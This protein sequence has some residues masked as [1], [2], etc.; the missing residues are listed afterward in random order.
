MELDQ[1]LLQMLAEADMPAALSDAEPS[2][3]YTFGG[4]YPA[5]EKSAMP[6]ELYTFE[7]PAPDCILQAVLR[8]YVE[9]DFNHF[10]F[11]F[12]S[13]PHPGLHHYD[14]D[15]GSFLALLRKDRDG[16]VTHMVVVDQR[17]F[18]DD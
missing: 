1:T 4:L 9:A 15:T 7:D 12:E 8:R 14:E 10:V 2:N 6:D 18:T 3:G 17:E 5:M 16:N 13:G 11:T